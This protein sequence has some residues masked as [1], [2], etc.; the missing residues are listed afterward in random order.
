MP[1]ITRTAT[2]Y[3]FQDNAGREYSVK[4]LNTTGADI[5][6]PVLISKQKSKKMWQLIES[7]ETTIAPSI[8]VAEKLLKKCIQY[9]N[10]AA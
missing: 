4:F 7:T 6:F 1:L 9:K 2:E 10:E 8:W 5:C 3:F